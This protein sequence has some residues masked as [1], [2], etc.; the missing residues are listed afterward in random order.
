MKQLSRRDFFKTSAVAAAMATTIPVVSTS[1]PVWAQAPSDRL[2]MGCIGVGSM[3]LGDAHG[4][5]LGGY[6]IDI[7]F[8]TVLEIQSPGSRC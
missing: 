8:L 2:R 5:R 1:K 7:Y 6:T 4:C 3:G